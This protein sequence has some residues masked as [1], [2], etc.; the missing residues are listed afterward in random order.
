VPAPGLNAFQVGSN[1][2]GATNS[3]D[4][5]A[6]VGSGNASGT[7][8]Q[9]STDLVQAAQVN[10]GPAFA[11]IAGATTNVGAGLANSGLNLGIGNNSTNVASLVQSAS[12]AGAVSNQ[13]TAAND[14]DGTGTI[15]FPCE[16]EVTPPEGPPATPE[17]PG[18]P[19]A[20]TL[21]RTGGAIEAQA[22]IAL[23]LLLLGF[24]LRRRSQALA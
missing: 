17:E 10:D 5:G 6:F 11:A 20:P 12:G 23:M 4:G 16:D 7:G 22:A 19:G 2:G 18:K 1:G 9:S 3:S 24:G 14:S 8:N 13:G 21:P 15:N